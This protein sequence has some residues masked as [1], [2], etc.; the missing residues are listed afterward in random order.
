M[1]RRLA[2]AVL[3]L[4]SFT[5]AVASTINISP[6][7]HGIASWYGKKF[8]GRRMANG[9]YYDPS[10]YTCASRTYPL[11]TLL[12]VTYPVTGLT[13][14]VR[15]TD[16]GPWFKNRVLDLS[17]AAAVTLGLRRNGIGYVVIQPLHIKESL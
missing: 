4:S 7:T 14:T 1:R 16:R 3:F 8:R 13:V 11:G 15:V 17:E 2:A 12:N 9:H 10:R 5:Q 6:V